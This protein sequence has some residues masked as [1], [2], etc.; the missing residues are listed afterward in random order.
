MKD[1][2]DLL[3]FDWDGTLFDSIGWIVECLQYAA[4]DCGLPVPSDY[5]ARSVIGLGLLEAMHALYPGSTPDLAA[6]VA[7]SYRRLYNT[8]TM[9]AAGLFDGVLDMLEALRGRGYR[10]AV[11]TG[12]NRAGL[13]HILDATGTRDYFHATRAA[14]ET[15]SK[16]NPAMLFQLM[17]ELRVA[18]ERTLMIGDSVHDLRMA[19]NAG[20]PAVAVGCGANGLD[21]LAELEPLVCLGATADV[22]SLFDS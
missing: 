11:A 21:E 10:L 13:D 20:I 19:Q 9:S 16:P 17:D 1:R 2:F 18:R 4:E 15:A 3:V 6:R 12:K 7:R 5:E 8:R 14:D 22:L